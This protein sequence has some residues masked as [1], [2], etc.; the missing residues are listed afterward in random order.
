MESYNTGMYV[1]IQV[2]VSAET[3]RQMSVDLGMSVEAELSHSIMV[4]FIA[5]CRDSP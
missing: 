3:L 1:Y 5:K 2:Y 4:R